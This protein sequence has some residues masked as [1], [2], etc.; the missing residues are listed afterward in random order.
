MVDILDSRGSEANMGN[1]VPGTH[2]APSK[3]SQVCRRAGS[4][5]LVLQIAI[6]VSAMAV[7]S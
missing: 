4:K 6:L 3:S 5:L 7:G 1:R 2:I